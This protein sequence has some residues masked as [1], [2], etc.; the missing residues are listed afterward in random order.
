[1]NAETWTAEITG[2]KP[3]GRASRHVPNLCRGRGC[4]SASDLVVPLLLQSALL[5]KDLRLSSLGSQQSPSRDIRVAV[6]CSNLPAD[7]L[8]MT[9]NLKSYRRVSESSPGQ[10]LLRQA[11]LAF[12]SVHLLLASYRL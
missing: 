12:A 10:S 6:A 8:P 2:S 11:P 7:S 1:M 4:P 5:T 3:V 9:A